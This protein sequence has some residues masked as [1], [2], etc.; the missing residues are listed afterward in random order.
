MDNTIAVVERER[1]RVRVGDWLFLY[2]AGTVMAIFGLWYLA[3]V[4][5]VF[6]PVIL[7]SPGSVWRE[8]LI[9]STR[10]YAGS[11]L[12]TNLL[13]SMGRLMSGFIG[14]IVVGV[15]V[16]LGMGIDK[17]FKAVMDPIIEFYRPLPPLAYLS[18]IILW[19]GI[20]EFSKILLLGLAALPPILVSSASAVRSVRIERIQGARSLGMQGFSLF[21][22]VILP[23]CLP[24]I[25]TSIRVAFGVAYTTLVAAEM[26]AASSGIGWMVLHASQFLV[27]TVVIIGVIVMGITGVLFEIMFRALHSWLIPWEGRS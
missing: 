25:L 6:S 10:G 1:R 20:G 27:S 8:F 11:S 21:R 2:S 17:R 22:F 13:V 15:P 7:P 24:E 12:W 14:A 3:G 18:L 16:G 19:F 23:S 26:V 4:F 5:H 9:V